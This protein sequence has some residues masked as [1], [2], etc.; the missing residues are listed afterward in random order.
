MDSEQSL[1]EKCK[2][3]EIIQTFGAFRYKGPGSLYAWMSRITV[4]RALDTVS[5]LH[6]SSPLS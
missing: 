6:L 5:T 3:A 2:R 4:N 1:S